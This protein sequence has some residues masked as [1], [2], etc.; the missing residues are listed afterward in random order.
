M[1]ADQSLQRMIAEGGPLAAIP[2]I[3]LVQK[4]LAEAR[5]RGI[6]PAE[7][8]PE[9]LFVALAPD[10]SPSVEIVRSDLAEGARGNP[11]SEKD[12]RAEVR[13][14]GTLLERLVFGVT[15]PREMPEGTDAGLATLIARCFEEDPSK[16]FATIDELEGA[17]ASFASQAAHDAPPAAIAKAIVTR[18][19][20]AALLVILVGMVA[21]LDGGLDGGCS[22][23]PSAVATT[24]VAAVTPVPPAPRT[25]PV[26]PRDPVVVSVQKKAR[27]PAGAVPLTSAAPAR[28]PFENRS[29]PS[30][31]R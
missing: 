12:E 21:S 1:I 8:T 2:A 14:V 10:G 26:I 9:S 30:G 31:T 6:S 5:A 4:A 7:L 16:H 27:W 17:L 20:A 22:P 19:L 15:T 28:P 11:A 3:D 24:A 18:A 25:T 13:A 29:V 23:A